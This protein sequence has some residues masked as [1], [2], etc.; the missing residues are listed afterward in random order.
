[1]WPS[2]KRPGKLPARSSVPAW[3][4]VGVASCHQ[5]WTGWNTVKALGSYSAEPPLF[6]GKQESLRG[7][8][9]GVSSSRELQFRW[10]EGLVLGRCDFVQMLLSLPLFLSWLAVFISSF[11]IVWFRDTLSLHTIKPTFPSL[12]SF[13]TWSISSL[14]AERCLRLTTSG[15]PIAGEA[16]FPRWMTSVSQIWPAWVGCMAWLCCFRPVTNIWEYDS[17]TVRLNFCLNISKP[18]CLVVECVL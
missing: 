17:P 10:I 8:G 7:L 18:Q 9:E 12:A 2:G 5:A 11:L 4:P 14:L 13:L 1:M 16:L 15:A 3:M 6:R